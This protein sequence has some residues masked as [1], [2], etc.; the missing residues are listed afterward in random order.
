LNRLILAVPDIKALGAK[1]IAAGYHLEAPIAQQAAYHV[2]V[3]QL[4]D[5]DGNRLELVQRLP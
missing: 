5:P 1:L 3:G 2:A 4:Q